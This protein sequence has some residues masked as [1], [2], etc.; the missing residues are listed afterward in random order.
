MPMKVWWKFYANLQGQ[1]WKFDANL[2][3][4]FA[5]LIQ[6]C[7]VLWKFDANLHG[8]MKVWCKL[9]GIAGCYESLM[10]TCMKLAG[11]GAQVWCKLAWSL[12]GWGWKFDSMQTCMELAWDVFNFIL[13]CTCCGL[14][15][16]F[17]SC[18]FLIF[19]P[20]QFHGRVTLD[21]GSCSPTCVIVIES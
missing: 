20:Q 11:L 15:T 18:R 2:Q 8:T 7:I 10:Q 17:C 3:G 12:Q 21:L 6:T 5:S 14:F 19:G 16:Q 1:V 4:C 13:I 9:A